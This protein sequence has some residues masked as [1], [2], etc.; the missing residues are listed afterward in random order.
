MIYYELEINIIEEYECPN[1]GNQINAVDNKCPN[2]GIEF[3]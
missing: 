2:C 1:C 3:G